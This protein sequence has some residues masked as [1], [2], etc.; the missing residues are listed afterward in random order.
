MQRWWLLTI[1]LSFRGFAHDVSIDG[2][3]GTTTSSDNNPRSGGAGLSVSGA[4]DLS[5]SW[6]LFSTV[7]YLRNFPQHT[8]DRSSPG[9]NVFNVSLGALW[10][11]TDHVMA[12]LSIQGSPPSQQ[13]TATQGSFVRPLIQEVQTFDIR[14]SSTASSLGAMATIGW[15]SM[16]GSR[17]ESMLDVTAGINYF[18]VTQRLV[19][20]DAARA[21]LL[22]SVCA[23]TSRPGPLCTL[24]EGAHTPL[25]QGRIGASYSAILIRDTTATMEGAFYVYDRNPLDVGYFSLATVGRSFDVGGG[26]PVNPLLWSIRPSVSHRVSRVTLKFLYQLG[27]YWGDTGQNHVVTLRDNVKL[28]PR[29]TL[30]CSLTAQTD[31]EVGVFSNRGFNGTLGVRYEF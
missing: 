22:D 23:S 25:F 11:A 28:L 31:V 10:I 3:F 20:A 6:S 12:M 1:L 5:D 29:V 7:G 14:V 26:V 17:W 16:G 18:D 19:V 9:G 4:V 13:L 27:F 24:R 15:A 30:L 8:S 2:A 21:A